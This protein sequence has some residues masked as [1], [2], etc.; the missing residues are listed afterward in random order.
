MQ[1][2]AVQNAGGG[3]MDQ[4]L[5]RKM[6]IGCLG[7]LTPIVINLLVV[8]LHTTLSNLTVIEAITYSIRVVAL[9]AAACIVIYLNFDEARPIKLF[10]LGIAAPAVLTGLLNGAVINN[11]QNAPA[12][13][14]PQSA[15]ATPG[16]GSELD[17]KFYFSFEVPSVVGSARAQGVGRAPGI[18][19]C[20]KPKD[21]TVGQQILK[22]L[23]GIVPENHWFVV[24]GSNDTSGG[25][26]SDVNA[27]NRRF[28]GKFTAEICAPPSGADKPY[29]VVIG[30]YLTYSDATKLK[31][32]AIAAGFPG[33]TWVWNPVLAK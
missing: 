3:S 10:Q 30:E 33:E 29:R 22:G 4:E 31:L 9:C 28:S 26:L 2:P 1:P 13:P 8:D 12:T 27:F 17:K 19:D 16:R 18:L 5:L 14:A 11:K 15:P 32:D 24:V 25:A 6:K 7:A 20:T 21:P 23:V